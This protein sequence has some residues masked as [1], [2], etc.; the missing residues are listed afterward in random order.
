MSILVDITFVTKHMVVERIL[1]TRRKI[2]HGIASFL[3]MKHNFLTCH[4]LKRKRSFLL[5][6]VASLLFYLLFKC[7]IDIAYDN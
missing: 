7:A 1:L 3:T 5:R 2:G 4:F 6:D